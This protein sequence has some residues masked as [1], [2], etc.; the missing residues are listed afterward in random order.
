M[1]S[2]GGPEAD[3][4][5]TCGAGYLYGPGVAQCCPAQVEVSRVTRGPGRSWR[6]SRHRAHHQPRVNRVA[7]VRTGVDLE[8]KN[9]FIFPLFYY[10]KLT[11][12]R[13]SKIHFNNVFSVFFI[14]FINNNTF[15]PIRKV[16]LGFIN[17]CL[18]FYAIMKTHIRGCASVASQCSL[19]KWPGPPQ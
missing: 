12:S 2:A 9:C 8:F 17:F 3:W 11:F 5:E 10:Q 19:A 6:S 1:L 14:I 18:V 7:E 16:H 13:Y 15:S 4:L